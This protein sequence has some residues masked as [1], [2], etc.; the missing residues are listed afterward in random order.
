MGPLYALFGMGTMH[1]LDR[2]N[3][4]LHSGFEEGERPDQV[5]AKSPMARLFRI[6]VFSIA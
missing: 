3:P 4:R 6:S 2:L 1:F 5:V